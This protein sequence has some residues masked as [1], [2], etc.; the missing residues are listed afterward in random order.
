MLTEKKFKLRK[1]V[2]EDLSTVMEMNR[3]C[4]PENYSSYFFLD[5]Y[6]NCP[7]AFL[8]AEVNGRAAGYVMCRIEYGFSE[9]RRFHMTRKGHVVSLAVMPDYRRMG[10]GE[11]LMM[12]AMKALSKYGA[13][14][15]FLEV[16]VTNE[17]AINLYRKLGMEIVR[18][19]AFYY[20]NGED[21]Y[22]MCKKL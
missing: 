2:P 9:L 12:E 6:R 11:A 5:L 20:Q 15:C 14:E 7:D 13:E 8:V 22:V 16:R 21:A 4:L 3:V 1:F 19:I 10:I 17:P 18:R